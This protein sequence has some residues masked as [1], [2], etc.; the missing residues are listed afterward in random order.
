MKKLITPYYSD[1][2]KP[3]I[4]IKH[5]PDS[6]SY[7][8]IPRLETL[9]N[10]K[11]VIYHRLFPEP[12]KRIFELLLILSRL[13]KQTK[14]IELFEPYLPYARQDRENKKGEV[15]SADVLCELL[16]NCGVIKL[17]TFDCHF[18]PRP[19]NFVRSG[20]KIENRT[21]SIVLY[22]YAKKYFGKNKFVMISPDEGASYFTE[23]AQGH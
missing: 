10:K 21:A 18:L 13:K 12:D 7:V 1:F 3:N 11:V 23:N 20:L 2:G 9:R 8:L 19:G 22:T 6:E 5:F 16:R 17:T 15:I 4:V 14:N